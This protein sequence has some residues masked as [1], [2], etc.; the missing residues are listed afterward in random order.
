[1]PVEHRNGKWIARA[2]WKGCRHLIGV[3]GSEEAARA[4]LAV[5]LEQLRNGTSPLAH[6][7]Y[8]MT[9]EGY[10]IRIGARYGTVKRWVSEGMPALRVAGLVRIDPKEADEWVKAHRSGSVAFERQSLIYIARRENDGAF[11]IGWSS[12]V[13]RRLS[14]LRKAHKSVA[15]VAAFPG[16]KPEELRIH[17][18]LKSFHLGGEWY[19]PAPEIDELLKTLRE[20]AA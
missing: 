8:E 19:S 9:I 10:A 17:K 2:K 18:R 3:F 1:M 13:T 20:V 4:A 14:E 11:K 15:L 12:D 6:G 5:A 7:P 16:D